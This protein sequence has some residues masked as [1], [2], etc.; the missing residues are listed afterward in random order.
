MS[1][2]LASRHT[3]VDEMF[4]EFAEKI[5]VIGSGLRVYVDE[6]SGS[7]KTTGSTFS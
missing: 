7:A 1:L 3:L 2:S 5:D 6:I 4:Y